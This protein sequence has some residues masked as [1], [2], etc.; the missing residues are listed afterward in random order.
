MDVFG[1]S[2]INVTQ[3]AEVEAMYSGYLKPDIE[4]LQQ[5]VIT[6]LKEISDLMMTASE[7]LGE[8][9]S[10]KKYTKF[11]Q[12]VD[13][14][15]QQVENLELVMSIIAPMKAGKST[16]IN[17]IVGQELLPSRSDAMTTLPTEV[18]FK[19][20]L[21]K[22]ILKLSQSV[23][24]VFSKTIAALRSNL[25][26]LDTDEMESMMAKYRH[27]NDLV[28]KIK[29]QPLASLVPKQETFGFNN[30]RKT[31]TAL[32]DI[33]RLCSLNEV[34][35]P[36]GK[37]LCL[38][39]K[40]PRIE[41]P[42]WQEED[43]DK[44]AKIGNLVIIDTPG[45]T[46]AG[47]EQKL[48][49]VVTKQLTKSAVVLIMLNFGAMGRTADNKVES[50]VEE[51]R[52]LQDS[53]KDNLYVLVNQIDRRG[54]NSRTPEEVKDFVK[55]AYGIGDSGENKDTN[56]VFEISAHWAL[57]SAN[58]F[59]RKLD[60]NEDA[61][62]N[63]IKIQPDIARDLLGAEWED[64]IEHA[65]LEELKRKVRKLRERSGFDDF[66][67]KA[68][69]ELMLS[70]AP[71]SMKAALKEICSYLKH[72]PKDVELQI[73]AINQKAAEIKKQKDALQSKINGLEDCRHRLKERIEEKQEQLNQKLEAIRI[74]LK[75]AA[76]VTIDDYFSQSPTD[77][78][79]KWETFASQMGVAKKIVEKRIQ[80]FISFDDWI[81]NYSILQFKWNTDYSVEL[82]SKADAEE[83]RRL[84]VNYATVRTEKLFDSIREATEEELK[85]SREEL[86]LLLDSETKP[87]IEEARE[88]LSKGFDVEIPPPP[89]E[90]DIDLN[91]IQ[92]S[93]DELP[94]YGYEEVD[95]NYRPWYFFGW[96]ERTRTVIKN[97]QVGNKYIV[98]LKDLIT[99]MNE[100]IKEKIDINYQGSQEYIVQQFEKDTETFFQNL[101]Q[102]LGGYKD[103]MKESLRKQ[104]S[105]EKQK[106]VVENLKNKLADDAREQIK[107]VDIIL[108][109][110]EY[111]L[112]LNNG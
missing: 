18:V 70:A 40:S 102:Y 39:L 41:T 14:A 31:L 35:D 59:L 81:K 100:V 72:I 67:K 87:I 43:A 105:E 54:K 17:A 99:K 83:F 44:T 91:S 50:E 65:S 15:K 71:E 25:Q 112:S 29:K 94:E 64:D 46:E 62:K 38:N 5:D 16:A 53:E 107:K 73:K 22:P 97:V 75:K 9:G 66:I 11:K 7:I 89:P 33:I 4:G 52:N 96:L 76:E 13:T 28:E 86:T 78:L 48:K 8:E 30:I 19:A 93:V 80:E 3:G 79:Q 77:A 92:P 82:S 95:E 98:N 45:G 63:D 57:F 32:N 12:E 1:S 23:V 108:Q 47:Q 58:F 20:D 68:M 27:L 103:Q 101:Q 60:K 84:A 10:G 111:F 69:E 24:S 85:N 2:V 109:R 21:K 90:P 55:E 110:I 36:I 74:P 61:A 37:L 34:D 26:E 104:G 49:A 51:I 42:F 88:Q 56:R 6:R 106:T